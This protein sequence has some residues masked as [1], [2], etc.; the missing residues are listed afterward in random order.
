ME[1]R[2]PESQTSSI[3]SLSAQTGRSAD[4]LVAEAVDRM[5]AHQAWF[6]AQ[7]Q[8]GLDQIA[9]GEFLEEEEMDERVARML[10]A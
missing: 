5:L 6:D 3:L 4:D 2:L 10:R 9:S 8:I 7:V 1:I